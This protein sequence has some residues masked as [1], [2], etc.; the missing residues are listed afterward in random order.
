[1][2]TAI[3]VALLLRGGGGDDAA[4]PGERSAAALPES[5][6]FRLL[7][8]LPLRACPS[9]AEESL[10]GMPGLPRIGLLQ[11]PQ[12]YGDAL[13]FPPAA[14][15]IG[16][17]DAG[18]A[19]RAGDVRVVPS[20]DVSVS[21]RCGAHVGPGICLVSRDREFRC[22]TAVEVAWGRAVA[23]TSS[24]ALV[25]IVPDSV[26]RVTIGDDGAAV[27][28][29]VYE[30]DS[31]VPAGEGIE[32][33]FQPPGDRG[34]RRAVAPELLARVAL[35]LDR[36][37]RN[38]QLPPPARE[39]L[40]HWPIEAILEDRARYWGGDDGIDFWAVPVVPYGRPPCAPASNVC[41]VAVTGSTSAAAECD[42]GRARGGRIWWL[43]Q[44]FPE[45][46]MMF[47]TVPDGVT[48]VRVSQR[49]ETA[50]LNA[51]DNVFGGALPWAYEIGDR[52]RV[53]L[54]RGDDEA[55]RLAGIVDAGG[56]VREVLGRLRARGY[57]TLELI[58]HAG[59]V[60]G[61]SIVYWWPG[62]AAR[63]DAYELAEAAGIE[64]V[65]P[66]RDTARIPRPVLD[67]HAPFVVFVGA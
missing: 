29:N 24:G 20:T 39:A 66:I 46:A 30:V 38:E 35:L 50:E 15:P 31:D 7:P 17:F 65:E 21:G 28:D 48:G 44:R 49:G 26:E 16:S 8:M 6:R 5:V 10:S 40:V 60:R 14:L 4:A 9:P 53:E 56:P 62:R 47:G 67:T 63:E 37:R 59:N 12:R 27:A 51:H 55:G 18:A 34:C 54:L 22:F 33:A 13:P 57:L 64:R 32:V 19:R 1:V 11:R 3:A 23:R 42:L 45:R 2:L 43:G 61:R 58:T 41:V 25:G 52:P 36:P